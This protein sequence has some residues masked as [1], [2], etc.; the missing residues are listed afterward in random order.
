[1]GETNLRPPNIGKYTLLNFLSPTWY[2]MPHS[3]SCTIQP[4]LIF[5]LQKFENKIDHNLNF[6]DN[7]GNF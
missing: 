3:R 2:G 1:M 5:I 6:N 4:R 7:Y